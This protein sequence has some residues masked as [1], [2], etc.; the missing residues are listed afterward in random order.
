MANQPQN[1]DKLF[2][3]K[4]SQHQVKPSKLAW[5]RLESQLPKKQKPERKIYWW[6][7]AAAVLVLIVSYSVFQTS[8]QT[9]QPEFVAETTQ[10]EEITP[11]E[12]SPSQTPINEDAQEE[13]EAKENINEPQKLKKAD[14][15]PSK[16]EV[17]PNQFTAMNEKAV[18][19]KEEAT[20][21]EIPEIVVPEIGIDQPLIAEAEIEFP[22]DKEIATAQSNETLIQEPAYKVTIISDGIKSEK[23]KNLIAGIGK[24]VNQVEGLLGKVDEG[25]GELQDAKNNLFASLISKKERTTEKP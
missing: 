9:S 10:P 23:D 18:D 2:E 21:I 13:E 1:L 17:V 16:K 12:E 4:L 8:E 5:E 14:P 6:A 22:L 7:A 20:E 25:F 15:R 3:E 19:K 11:Q 24:R